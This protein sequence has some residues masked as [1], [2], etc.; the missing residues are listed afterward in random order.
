MDLIEIVIYLLSFIFLSQLLV[1][2]FYRKYIKNI[3]RNVNYIND[4]R[5]HD[6]YDIEEL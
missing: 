3:K 5:R 4:S 2:F 1:L 6:D